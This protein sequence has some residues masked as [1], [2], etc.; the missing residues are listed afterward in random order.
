MGTEAIF[1]GSNYKERE[2]DPLGAYCLEFYT[3][4]KVLVLFWRTG[5]EE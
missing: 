5:I 4:A 1:Q 3:V 2:V